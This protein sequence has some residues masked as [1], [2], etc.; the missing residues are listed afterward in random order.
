MPAAFLAFVGFLSVRVLFGIIEVPDFSWWGSSRVIFRLLLW[1]WFL[2]SVLQA[3]EVR[4]HSLKI[5]VAACIVAVTLQLFGVGVSE[6]FG[7]MGERISAFEQNANALGMIYT[8]GFLIAV[9]F[10]RISFIRFKLITKGLIWLG[11]GTL[12][13]IGCLLMASRA[14]AATSALGLFILFFPRKSIAASFRLG[15]V[16]LPVL[17]AVIWM[18]S[19]YPGVAHRFDPSKEGAMQDEARVRMVPMVL[20][21]FLQSPIYGTGPEGYKGEAARQGFGTGE[22]GLTIHNNF[23]LV[24]VEMGLIGLT[25]FSYV[26]WSFIASAWRI[27]N[28]EGLLPLAMAIPILLIALTVGN[29]IFNWYFYF[30]FG[31]ILASAHSLPSRPLPQTFGRACSPRVNGYLGNR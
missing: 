17:G 20:E 23:L 12:C 29:I 10:A 4:R 11:I 13:F 24:A 27:R 19:L 22:G 16:A 9:D 5:Y 25:A 2:F 31:Y 18:L 7:L 1:A 8:I 30:V 3:S 6:K 15:I 28:S 26:M 21:I 14:A